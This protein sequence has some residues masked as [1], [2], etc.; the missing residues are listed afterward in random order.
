MLSF[1]SSSDS[2]S[3][4]LVDDNSVSKESDELETSF[5]IESFVISGCGNGLSIETGG[6]T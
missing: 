4:S 2:D 3:E 1:C 6:V 5:V